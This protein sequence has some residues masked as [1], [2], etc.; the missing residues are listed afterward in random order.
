MQSDQGHCCLLYYMHQIIKAI[1]AD[2]QQ[3]DLLATD[4]IDWIDSSPLGDME[5]YNF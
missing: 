1:S 4:Q 5:R 3:K 2:R